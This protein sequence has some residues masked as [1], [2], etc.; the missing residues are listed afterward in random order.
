MWPYRPC[1]GWRDAVYP[2]V[3]A[4]EVF[5]CPSAKRR[6]LDSYAF[7]AALSGVELA[8]ISRPERTVLLFDGREGANV[9][10]DPDI[11]R[12]R[13]LGGANVLFVDGHVQWV[14]SD[15]VNAGGSECFQ[16]AWGNWWG[17]ADFPWGVDVWAE[18][19]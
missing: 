9:A 14:S 1:A 11:A 17:G 6:R 3:N 8:R 4:D 7:N 15:E 19:Y 12:L 10:G 16:G 5:R 2:Y 13:H 18:E